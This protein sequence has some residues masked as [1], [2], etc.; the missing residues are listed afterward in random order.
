MSDMAADNPAATDPVAED[1]A[2]GAYVSPVVDF[3]VLSLFVSI[4]AA[5]VVAVMLP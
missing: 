2:R 4:L 1:S 5:T 3:V